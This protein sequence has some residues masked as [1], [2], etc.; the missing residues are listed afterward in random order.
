MRHQVRGYRS[1]PLLMYGFCMLHQVILCAS[2]AAS[3]SYVAAGW[4]MTVPFDSFS[5]E[6]PYVTTAAIDYGCICAGRANR[7]GGRVMSYNSIKRL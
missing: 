4:G 3:D 5:D 6:H 1:L 2:L 7:E